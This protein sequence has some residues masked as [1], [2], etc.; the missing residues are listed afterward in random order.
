MIILN[1]S[2]LFLFLFF[3]LKI[4]PAFPGTKV[5]ELS[6]NESLWIHASIPVLWVLQGSAIP[7]FW[8]LSEK[9]F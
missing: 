8:R 7:Y 3:L 9:R 1:V 6:I 5:L 4:F 2:I